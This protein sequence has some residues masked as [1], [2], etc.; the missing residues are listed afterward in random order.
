MAPPHKLYT[1]RKDVMTRQSLSDLFPLDGHEFRTRSGNVTARVTN[2]FPSTGGFSDQ[3]GSC[4][5]SRTAKHSRSYCPMLR[6]TRSRRQVSSYD[7]LDR[8]GLPGPRGCQQN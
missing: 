4:S 7:V 6:R 5:N 2:N 8:G 1:R 3:A